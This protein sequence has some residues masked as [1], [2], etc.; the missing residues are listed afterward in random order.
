MSKRN[1]FEDKTVSVKCTDGE[2]ISGKI[3]LV[4]EEYQDLII[5]VTYT[6][7]PDKW[8]PGHP[9]PACVYNITLQEIDS[10]ETTE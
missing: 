8:P 7:R 3:S 9:N 5:D 1:A 6:S 4:D 10:I 2:L